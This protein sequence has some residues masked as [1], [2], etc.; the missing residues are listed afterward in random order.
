M[1][2]TVK[3]KLHFI[4]SCTF[5]LFV[6][7]ENYCFLERRQQGRFAGFSLFISNTGYR[8]SSSLCY[9]D[10]PELPPLNFSTECTL[11]GRYVIFYNERLE[12]VT[13]PAGYEVVTVYTELCEVTIK[14]KLKKSHK[15]CVRVCD[16]SGFRYNATWSRRYCIAIYFL[17]TGI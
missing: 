12:G 9:K 13:Y 16:Y 10:G 17:S 15:L 14:G 6:I 11:S 4:S 7:K 8:D 1:K 5:V 2:K 3:T